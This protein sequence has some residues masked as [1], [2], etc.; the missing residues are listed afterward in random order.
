MLCDCALYKFTIDIDSD[1]DIHWQKRASSLSHKNVPLILKVLYRNKWWKKMSVNQLAGPRLIWKTAVKT[2]AMVLVMVLWCS[3]LPVLVAL[4]PGCCLLIVELRSITGH[5]WSYACSWYYLLV[6]VR[7]P[8][9]WWHCATVVNMVHWLLALLTPSEAA[10]A[11]SHIVAFTS[12]LG[13][14]SA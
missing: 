7:R 3:I 10:F 12:M 5:I 4:L 1:I 2:E 14:R 9:R 11:V 8:T 6:Q 13:Q